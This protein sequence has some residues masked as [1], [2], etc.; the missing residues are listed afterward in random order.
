MYP[1]YTARRA[2]NILDARR[3]F[4]NDPSPFPFLLLPLEI[5]LQ[6]YDCAILCEEDSLTVMWNES[7]EGLESAFSE[8][9][10]DGKDEMLLNDANESRM[11]HLE[12]TTVYGWSPGILDINAAILR[13]NRQIFKEA[14]PLF[15]R[16]HAFD[17]QIEPNTGLSFLQRISERARLNIRWIHMEL[18]YRLP[19][20]GYSEWNCE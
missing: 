15:Y 13:T 12:V 14:Q 16:F 20:F 2:L 19:N 10:H 4:E 1:E 17:F 11:I 9:E 3:R 8:D 5:R 6:V 18:C 7:A